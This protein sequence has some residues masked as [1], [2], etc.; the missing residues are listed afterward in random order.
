MPARIKIMQ[1]DIAAIRARTTADARMRP[2]TSESSRP[3]RLPRSA[4][5]KVAAV[6]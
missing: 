6:R 2:A 5:R 3:P 4:A 1:S